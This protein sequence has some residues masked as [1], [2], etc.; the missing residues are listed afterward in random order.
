MTIYALGDHSPQFDAAEVFIAPS[1]DVIG[2]VTLARGVNIWF[3]AVLRGDDNAI[4]IGDH[5]NRL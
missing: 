3:G 4:N 1:A 5:D 2:N